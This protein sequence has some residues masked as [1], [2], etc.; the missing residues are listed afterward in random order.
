MS[1]PFDPRLPRV[2][3]VIPLYNKAK[4]IG[5]SLASVLKQTMTDFEVV[6]VDDG[7]TDG[8]ADVVR[9]FE[10]SRIRL[11]RQSNAGQSAARNR[12]ISEARG[13]LVAFIDADDF[14]F[15]HFLDTVLALRDRFPQAGAYATAF[16]AVENGSVRRFPHMEVSH[17][18]EGEL[19]RDYFRSCT[20]GSSMISSSSVMIPKTVFDRIGHFPVGERDAPD[21]HMWARIA[22]EYPIAWSTMECVIWNL[23]AQNRIAGRIPMVDPSFAKLL[24]TAIAE[25]RVTVEQAKWIRAYI[26]RFRILYAAMNINQ[27]NRTHGLRI[28]WL[29]RNAPGRR[30]EWWKTVIRAWTP[31]Q[32]L[33]LRDAVRYRSRV[34]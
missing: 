18:L 26:A 12:G 9:A 23:D 19:I 13:D 4:N 21:L 31:R 6:I 20:L 15:P 11:I 27:G 2:S 34:E 25:G 22:L 33:R 7:S 3:V 14:W 1:E 8:S 5:P 10:D 16:V 29:A 28:L 17:L 30:R 24:E 32:M